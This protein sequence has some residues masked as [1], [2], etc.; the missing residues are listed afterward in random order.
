MEFLCKQTLVVDRIC[1][2][3]SAIPIELQTVLQSGGVEAECTRA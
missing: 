1:S 3:A 2:I